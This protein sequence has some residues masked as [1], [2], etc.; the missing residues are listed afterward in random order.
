MRSEAR[1]PLRL[2][3][4]DELPDAPVA[5]P[6]SAHPLLRAAIALV[7]FGQISLGIAQIAGFSMVDMVDGGHIGNESAAWNIAIGTAL[8]GVARAGK[9]PAGVLIMLVTFVGVLSLVTV[10]DALDGRVGVARLG[11]HVVALTGCALVV[12]L[13]R[14]TPGN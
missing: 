11:T 6:P 12:F 5:R 10:S 7:G 2:V 9:C 4:P 8:L 13:R 1:P 3:S 14:R